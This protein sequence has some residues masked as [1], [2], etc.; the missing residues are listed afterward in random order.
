MSHTLAPKPLL[1]QRPQLVVD[2]SEEL[3]RGLSAG[4]VFGAAYLLVRRNLWVTFL[5]HGF[6]DRLAFLAIYIGMVNTGVVDRSS[7][8][9]H[10]FLSLTWSL[11]MGRLK[12]LDH[13]ST[14][15]LAYGTQRLLVTLGTCSGQKKTRKPL[16][17]Y[18][19]SYVEPIGLE[20]TTSC[21]PF[22]RSRRPRRPDDAKPRASALQAMHS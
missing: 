21:M 13:Y 4:F 1:G 7:R 14:R 5:A 11:T 6:L 18:G 16:Q 9:Q 20:P 10:V 19:L 12:S 3:G 17:A 8:R 15:G 22:S 2:R